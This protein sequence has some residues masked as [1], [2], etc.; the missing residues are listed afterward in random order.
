MEF[1]FVGTD[2]RFLHLKRRLEA[3]GHILIPDSPNIIAPPA[4]RRGIPYWDDPAYTIE[5][6]ALTAEGAAELVMRRA[7]R[8]L[9]ELSVLIAGF[10]RI[11][12]LLADK[13]SFL[14]ARVTVAARDPADRAMAAARGHSSVDINNI[15]L[16]Y[17]VL[18]N[19]VPAQILRG[20]HGASLC[21]DLASKPGGWADN[22]PVLKVPGLPGLYAP[23]SGA[24]VMADA[25][26]R[27]MEV[28]IIE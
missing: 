14:G 25:I 18:V 10:G 26:Y 7:D 23:R 16:G 5:N 11:G 17:D 2:P 9:P 20:D 8:A 3:D 19:T 15:P 1:T 21:I 4:E 24:D 13:L 6:A 28:D 27:V 22:T 12:S